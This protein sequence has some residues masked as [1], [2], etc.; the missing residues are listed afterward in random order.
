MNTAIKNITDKFNDVDFTDFF[1]SYINTAIWSS[2]CGDG[3]ITDEHD[4]GDIEVKALQYLVCV[5]YKFF[6][7]TKCYIE[8]EPEPPTCSDGC[9]VFA[10][11][12]H[13]FWLT[14]A[15]HGAGFWDG[16]WPEYGDRL[17]KHSKES[18]EVTL[19]FNDNG[20]IDV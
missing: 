11:A 1:E 3:D 4:A 7:E 6:K 19:Y 10:M 13:D 18:G 12:G 14:S 9:N 15:G 20:K 8:G 2:V 5:A 17:T 16:D